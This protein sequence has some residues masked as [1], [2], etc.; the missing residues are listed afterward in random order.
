MTKVV[1]TLDNTQTRVL[2]SGHSNYDVSGKD[3]VCSS[4]S[5]LMY[6]VASLISELT[7]NFEFREDEKSATM[8]LVINE[9]NDTIDAI[10]RCLIYSFETIEEDYSDYF[11]LTIN[12]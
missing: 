4:V 12:K 1:I 9:K 7:K 5:S 8:D 3:I 2:V 11:K 10:I 6:Y